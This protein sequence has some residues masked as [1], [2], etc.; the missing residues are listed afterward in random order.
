MKVKVIKRFS[1]KYVR[2]IRD[3]GMEI[4]YEDKRAAEL[5]DLGLV[6]RVKEKK[7]ENKE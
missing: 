6:E 1:D 5:I 3:V 4:E 7:I 2:E